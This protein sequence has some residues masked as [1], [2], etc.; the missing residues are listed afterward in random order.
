MRKGWRKVLALLGL[1]LLGTTVQ[2][3]PPEPVPGGG[4]AVRI[5]LEVT[6]T[7]RSGGADAAPLPVLELELNEGRVLEALAWPSGARRKPEPGSPG[8]L[9]LGPGRTGRVRALIEAPLG[10]S[11]RLQ[12]AGQ[13][14]LIPILALHRWAAADSAPGPGRD[15][16]GAPPLGCRAPRPGT[17]R[18]HGRA[19][20]DAPGFG[21]LQHLDSRADRGR[22]TLHGQAPPGPASRARLAGRTARGGDHQPCARRRRRSGMSR[23]RRSRG[24]MCSRSRPR[25]SR[26]RV[27]RA[28]GWDA[29]SGDG[30]TRRPRRR[31]CGG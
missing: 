22:R 28:R 12:R 10:A 30:G 14:I 3:A 31:R 2:A 20:G 5:A 25:G 27:R 9:D 23:L 17:E 7:V 24:R 6:W 15:R 18:R 13:A 26:S 11:L 4:G 21:R 16:R 1:F 19:G 8:V 29:G